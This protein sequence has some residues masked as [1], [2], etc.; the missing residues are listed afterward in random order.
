M[1]QDPVLVNHFWF[2]YTKDA[3][4]AQKFNSGDV[5]LV[6]L[7]NMARRLARDRWMIFVPVAAFESDE[8]ER[9]LLGSAQEPI[10]QLVARGC[11]LVER[12]CIMETNGSC[13]YKGPRVAY[14]AP[15]HLRSM[16][17]PRAKIW[18]ITR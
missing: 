13:N 1:H 12:G 9:L 15:E 5:W 16:L 3:T 10:A 11:T 14:V 7:Q 2:T 6:H 18:P 8:R 17:A 4:H